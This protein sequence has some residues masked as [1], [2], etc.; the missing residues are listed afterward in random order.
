M[1][2]FISLSKVLAKSDTKLFFECPGCGM[3][4]GINID[5]AKS[6]AWSWDGNADAPTFSPSV[7]VRFDRWDP[8]ASDENLDKIHSGEIVQVKNEHV[9]HSFVRNG[10]IEFLNDCTHGYAGQ[11]V[12]IPVWEIDCDK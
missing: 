12:P 7:L 2:G 10:N 6:P 3:P 11:T 5:T 8:P 9:C 4:H 1:A